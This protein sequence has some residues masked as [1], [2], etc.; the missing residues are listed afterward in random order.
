MAGERIGEEGIVR[1]FYI[2]LVSSSSAA[3]VP[4]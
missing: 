4:D 2:L 1:F 3:V